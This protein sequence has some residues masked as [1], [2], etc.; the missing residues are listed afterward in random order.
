MTRGVFLPYLVP[1]ITG[2]LRDK[3]A[4]LF[5]KV[6]QSRRIARCFQRLF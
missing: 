6:E 1:L 3:T 5:R 2:A 4:L